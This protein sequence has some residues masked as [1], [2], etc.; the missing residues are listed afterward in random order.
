MGEVVGPQLGPPVEAQLG[1]DRAP[2]AAH[3]EVGEKVRAGL[4]GKEPADPVRPG[5]DVVAVQPG[6]PVQVERVADTS[7]AP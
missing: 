6:K 2:E 1:E 4:V 7:R 5:E 3:E